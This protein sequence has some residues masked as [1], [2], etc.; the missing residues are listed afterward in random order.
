QRVDRGGRARLE[1]LDLEQRH[2]LL[3]L[4]A[5]RAGRL[6]ANL[7]K[8]ADVVPE[9]GERHVI[10]APAGA[11]APRASGLH[12]EAIISSG[13]IHAE[14]TTGAAPRGRGRPTT[15]Q[16]AAPSYRATSA[17]AGPCQPL[18]TPGRAR[19]TVSRSRYAPGSSCTK[20]PAR[21]H[22]RPAGCWH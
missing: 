16:V 4:D 18:R 21:A 1:R 5:R 9:I 7:E 13:D 22:S 6:L 10:D 11:R 8:A 19:R 3:R 20:N 15:V 12:R 17:R 14:G 2:V